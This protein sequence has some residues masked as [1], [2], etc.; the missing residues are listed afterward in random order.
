M[1]VLSRNQS[2][3]HGTNFLRNRTRSS[4]LQC[5]RCAAR[6][7]VRQTYS[8]HHHNLEKA[9][10]TNLFAYSQTESH[11]HTVHE[12]RAIEITRTNAEKSNSKGYI[13]RITHLHADLTDKYRSCRYLFDVTDGPKNQSSNRWVD[14]YDMSPERDRCCVR[15]G[16]RGPA[17]SHV[18]I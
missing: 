16:S 14:S 18:F 1:L 3:A 8:W 4:S 5:T 6:T 2:L 17:L 15:P 7:L 12:P 10:I 13:Y 11:G 9:Q